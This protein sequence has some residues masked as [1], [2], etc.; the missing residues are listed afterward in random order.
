MIDAVRGR[1]VALAV[2][3][4]G[5]VGSQAGH[6]LAY[7]LRF[8]SAA[9]HL[10]SSGAHA[11][12]PFLA[13]TA[14]GAVAVT[15]LV[16]I[17]IIGLARLLAG[18]SRPRTRSGPKYIEL[19]AALFTIQL[20]CFIT[21]E[22][23]E[24]LVA[25]AAVDSAAHLLLWGTLG[26][27]PVAAIA[28]IALGWLWTRFESAV[29]NLRAVLAIVPVNRACGTLATATWPASNGAL[30]LAQVAGGSLSKR[31]PPTSL[32]LSS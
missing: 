8:G 6:L 4:A 10:Q 21:Q 30:L 9:Q 3:G 5:V 32:R 24:A 29:Q 19:L 11:Y 14:L 16:A 28:A 22:A 12:F 27:V 25:G 18:G 20:A 2:L 26:Q 13:K 15:L 31:G 7:Q 23:G 1:R 17:F